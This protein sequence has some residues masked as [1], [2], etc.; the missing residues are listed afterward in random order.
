MVIWTDVPTENGQ[1]S[2]FWGFLSKLI[3]FWSKWC[4]YLDSASGSPSE[5]VYFYIDS[6]ND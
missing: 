6:L 1:K 2:W 3:N 4:P 5:N